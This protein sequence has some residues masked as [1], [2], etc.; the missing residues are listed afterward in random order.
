MCNSSKEFNSIRKLNWKKSSKKCCMYMTWPK[1]WMTWYS[2]RESS[3]ILSV[4]NYLNPSRMWRQ[5]TMK[6]NKQIP[7]K[8]NP[9]KSTYFF[10]SCWSESPFPLFSW[11]LYELYCINYHTDPLNTL[12]AISLTSWSLSCWRFFMYFFRDS[13]SL[14]KA[15]YRPNKGP[16][17]LIL[18]FYILS[19]QQTIICE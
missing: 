11:S 7:G 2:S 5:H 15:L 17:T 13:F 6:S 1:T 19:E 18:T 16:Q 8:E 3:G 4:I 14:G 12:H 10:P 9:K